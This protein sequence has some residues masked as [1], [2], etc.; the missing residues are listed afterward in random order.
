M[1]KK[2]VLKANGIKPY[3]TGLAIPIFSLRSKK[4]FGIGQFSDLKILADFVYSSGMDV[5]QILP[6]NDTTIFMDWRDSS[7]Y[8]ANSVFAL[9]PIY[10]DFTDYLDKFKKSELK[11]ILDEA[12]ELN[13]LPQVDYERVSNFKWR[14]AKKVYSNYSKTIFE[15]LSFKNFYQSRKFWIEPYACF[16]YFRDNYHTADFRLWKQNKYHE[17]L[18]EELSSDPEIFEDLK[19]HIMIQYL[20]HKQLKEAVDY[21]HKLGI[22]VKGDVSVGI[23]RKSVDAWTLPELFKLD[24]QA[25]A[26]PDIFSSSGQ[27]WEY[28]T[29]NWKE[30][31]KDGYSWWKARMRSMA[32]YF[33]IYRLDHILGFFRIWENPENS[34]RALLGHFSPALAMTAEEI[35]SYGIPLRYWGVDRF[36][37]PFIK[38]WVIDEIFGRDQRDEVIQRFLKYTGFGNYEFKEEFGDERKVKMAKGLEDY[39]REGLYRLHE[40]VIFI[41]DHENPKLYHPR[42]NLMDTISYREFGDAF[43]QQL[44]I[45]HNNYFYGRNYAYWQEKAEEILPVIKDASEMLACGED[46][47]MVPDNVPSVMWQLKILRLIIERMP[48]DSNFITDLKWTPYLSVVTTS[49]HDITPLSLWWQEDKNLIQRYYNEVM[50]L[51]GMAPKEA[52]PSII[53]EIL[54]R[55]LNTEAMLAIFPIQDWLDTQD[56]LRNPNASLTRINNPA[57]SYYYWRYRLHLD[58]EDLV[59]NQGFENFLSD[60]IKNSKR[61]TVGLTE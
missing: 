35:E 21:C 4:S 31:S 9:H 36:I 5:I 46:L 59:D 61:S 45:I 28:P 7:P 58:L 19:L 8:R 18:F 11:K 33:D 42:I 30:M 49:S 43:K 32:D 26:P 60:F 12:K 38:D 34:V 50:G 56:D 52:N 25:G 39:E 22:A 54:K 37:R 15:N 23:D 53:R 29:Y 20:L 10:L 48:T 16:C 17:G 41:P 47:G 51:E 40:N 14:L 44:E 1:A 24:K 57:Y 27:N 55:N 13:Q 6:I 2:F 3:H